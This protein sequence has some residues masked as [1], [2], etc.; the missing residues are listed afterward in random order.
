MQLL[1]HTENE[2]LLHKIV[3]CLQLVRRIYFAPLVEHI[4]PQLY[5]A[6]QE[7]TFTKLQR[8]FHMMVAYVL[9]WARISALLTREVAKNAFIVLGVDTLSERNGD[10]ASV[11]EM[12]LD[13]EYS[14]SYQDWKDEP[15]AEVR[16]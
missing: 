14:V 3:H 5:I 2:E 13:R 15:S 1:D 9:P 16:S 12:E 6:A 8:T 4:L 10:N 7:Q 11:D